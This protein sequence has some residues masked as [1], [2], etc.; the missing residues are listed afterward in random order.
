[1]NEP[2][3]DTSLRKANGKLTT[4]SIKIILDHIFTDIHLDVKCFH[5]QNDHTAQGLLIGV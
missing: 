3:S 1:M 5:G 4:R 2:L